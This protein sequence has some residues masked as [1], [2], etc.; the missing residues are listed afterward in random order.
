VKKECEGDIR[1][2]ME[3]VTV[4]LMRR[5]LYGFDGA[6][7]IWVIVARH[8]LIFPLIPWDGAKIISNII[9]R[10]SFHWRLDISP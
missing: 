3:T 9:G 1:I 10:R 6:K 8:L 5:I 7:T 4:L 2:V